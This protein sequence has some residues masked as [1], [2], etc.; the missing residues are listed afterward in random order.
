MQRCK[1]EC[2][3]RPETKD[4]MR[5][6]LVTDLDIEIER[7]R[8]ESEAYKNKGS[9]DEFKYE[10]LGPMSNIEKVKQEHE[11]KLKEL[12]AL[13]FKGKNK[14]PINKSVEGEMTYEQIMKLRVRHNIK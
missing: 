4:E 13:Y 8:R 10:V 12:Q 1:G 11:K 9:Y 14:E 2:K 6:V 3:S 7:I 5:R